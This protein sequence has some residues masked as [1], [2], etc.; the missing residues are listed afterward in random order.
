MLPRRTAA[1]GGGRPRGDRQ[2][3]LRQRRAVLR[4][5]RLQ[6]RLG[7][8]PCPIGLW[9]LASLTRTLAA[10]AAARG[11]R[12]NQI[13][14]GTVRTRAWQDRASEREVLREVYPLGRVGEPEDI[15]AAVTFLASCDGAWIT[16]T[17]L[18]VDG[19]L[20]AVNSGFERLH[21]GRAANGRPIPPSART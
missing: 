17:T 3:R 2:H 15:A 16:G 1:S 8:L 6:R 13:N 7:H 10:E 20:L 4:R 12:V 11:V 5:P 14:P 9:G 19:G 21:A 18:R